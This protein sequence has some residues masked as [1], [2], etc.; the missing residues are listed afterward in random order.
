MDVI[1]LDIE[2]RRPGAVEEFGDEKLDSLRISRY[3]IDMF[4]PWTVIRKGRSELLDR[5]G[6]VAERISDFMGNT[7]CYSS[8]KR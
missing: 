5:N 3:N 7:G 8:C 6:H 1:W 2:F 4:G